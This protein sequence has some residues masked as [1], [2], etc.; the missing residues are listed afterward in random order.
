MRSGEEMAPTKTGANNREE[1]SPRGGAV[2]NLSLR[3]EGRPLSPAS[4][5]APNN[6]GG[7]EGRSA[8][9]TPGGKEVA[10]TKTGAKEGEENSPRSSAVRNTSP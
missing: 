9:S 4:S 7:D 8:E 3:G 10:P 1:N 5:S 6:G 2:T